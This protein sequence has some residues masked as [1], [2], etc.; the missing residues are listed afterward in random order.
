MEKE[1]R[2]ITCKYCGAK[3]IA[4]SKKRKFCSDSHKGR[5][6]VESKRYWIINK[7]YL[8]KDYLMSYFII[9]NKNNRNLN[10]TLKDIDEVW[11]VLEMSADKKIELDGKVILFFSKDKFKDGIFKN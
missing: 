11:E 6:S 3:V 2:T 4:K 8:T 10:E 5:Y 1:K 9:D 7:P